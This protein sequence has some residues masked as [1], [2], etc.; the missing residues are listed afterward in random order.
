MKSDRA[1]LVLVLAFIAYVAG[2]SV[3]AVNRSTANVPGQTAAR[4][5]VT[6]RQ[7]APKPPPGAYCAQMSPPPLPTPVPSG[8]AAAS[9]SF[10]FRA[11]YPV[12]SPSLRPD[13]TMY[14]W[15]GK[16]PKTA[17]TLLYVHGGGLT[18]GD[19]LLPSAAASL[20]VN[21]NMN[22]LAPGYT[23]DPGKVKTL[24]NPEIY[25][26]LEDVGCAIAWTEKHAQAYFG[27]GTP[28]FVLA[29]YSAG[30][31]LSA[32]AAL[33]RTYVTDSGGTL[34][35]ILGVATMSGRYDYT[36]TPYDSGSMAPDPTQ[37]NYLHGVG[38]GPDYSPLRLVQKTKY[39]WLL[40]Y[41][42]AD[43]DTQY[44]SWARLTQA[45]ANAGATTY[46]YE[47]QDEGPHGQGEHDLTN[48]NS[49]FYKKVVNFF[50]NRTTTS[51]SGEEVVPL[52]A[53]SP[54]RLAIGVTDV[55]AGGDG[56]VWIL[57]AGNGLVAKYS[58]PG[59]ATPSP[60]AK[61]G[62]TGFGF[63]EDTQGMKGSR[64]A[65]DGNGDPWVVSTNGSVYYLTN[66]LIG[67][68]KENENWAPA[69]APPAALP[70]VDIG[71]GGTQGSPYIW[72]IGQDANLYAYNQT[73][74]S[75]TLETAP[76]GAEIDGNSRLAISSGGDVW[77]VAG[78]SYYELPLGGT[79]TK[80]TVFNAKDVGAADT[81]WLI[82][83]DDHIYE[84]VGGSP[85]EVDSGVE[86]TNMT[87]D[88]VNLPWTATPNQLHLLQLHRAPT[89][90]DLLR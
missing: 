8:T 19:S 76:T 38:Q 9:G 64:I 40:T 11:P 28:T 60:T 86:V 57:A 23:T 70:V 65:V 17:T 3:P 25:Y 24:P 62:A 77:L 39:P 55:A 68:M 63:F 54:M 31:E 74:M 45:L 12:P 59:N 21:A 71:A 20:A 80:P 6:T 66:G 83:N 75:F 73:S 44:G 36:V 26:A 61:P 7:S 33:D 32:T 35:D 46:A 88:A 78:G 30:A 87:V 1:F 18:G 84:I 52:N 34:A 82:G 47:N 90:V 85:Q 56:S 27:N 2:C 42:Q 50:Q 48:P 81:T 13:T 14:V 58:N 72:I 15:I 29:G 69:S 53:H 5:Q 10:Q 43:A 49:D 37:W 22:V 67:E 89:R 79:W 41:E 4:K 16:T 51:T